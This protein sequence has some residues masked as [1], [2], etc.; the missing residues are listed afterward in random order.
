MNALSSFQAQFA[1]FI[2]LLYISLY[3]LTGALVTNEVPIAIASLL[4]LPAFARLLGFLVIGFWSIPALFV[5][6]LFCVDLGLNLTEQVVVS[7][8]IATG[9]PLGIWLAAYLMRLE[10]ALSN[11]TPSRLLWLSLASSLGNTIFYNTGIALVGVDDFNFELS[12]IIFIGDAVGTWV[13]ISVIKIG[14]T[15]YGRW[16]YVP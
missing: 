11:L 8:F 16:M 5:A 3:Y 10:P 15:A 9:A 14:L 1:A 13:M 2:T 6:G 12:T 4:F 7:G